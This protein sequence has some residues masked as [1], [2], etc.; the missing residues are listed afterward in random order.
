M[1][2]ESR[3]GI[4]AKFYLNKNAFANEQY[5]HCATRLQPHMPATL[6]MH[7]NSDD[8]VKAPGG[9]V[10]PPFVVMKCGQTLEHWAHDHPEA[11]F[12]EKFDVR[13]FYH[14]TV[15]VCCVLCQ[16]VRGWMR[17]HPCSVEC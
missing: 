4:A 5:L 9:Y 6:S 12:V 11:S 1:E 2:C 17:L 8:R 7:V 15:M 14:R 3:Q 16:H 13:L 10:F